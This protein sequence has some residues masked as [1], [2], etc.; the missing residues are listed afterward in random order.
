VAGALGAG[1]LS[2]LAADHDQYLHLLTTYAGPWFLI[3]FVIGRFASTWWRAVVRCT[4]FYAVAMVAFYGTVQIT[5]G[6]GPGRLFV[7]WIGMSVLAGPALGVLGWASRRP[8]WRGAAAVAVMTGALLAEALLVAFR[9]HDP[10]RILL[11][12]VDAVTAAT[13]CVATASDMR[14]ARRTAVLVIPGFGVGACVFFL[15]SI[16]VG[17]FLT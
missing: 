12:A 10:H 16:L 8:G 3:A 2:Q 1:I 11:V 15:P 6:V 14:Q 13:A 4:I 9:D 17:S 5:M 7:F